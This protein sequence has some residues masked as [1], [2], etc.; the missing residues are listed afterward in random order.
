MSDWSH[1]KFNF[2]LDYGGVATLCYGVA[3]I[4]A[5]VE[6]PNPAVPTVDV[7]DLKDLKAP[8]TEKPPE[9]EVDPKPAQNKK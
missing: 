2:F 1:V 3:V 9:I 7:S 6:K 8:P 5:G 4:V